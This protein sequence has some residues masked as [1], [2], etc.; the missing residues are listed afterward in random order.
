MEYT[1]EKMECVICMQTTDKMYKVNCGSS[2]DHTMCIGCEGEWRSKMPLQDGMRT[3][4]CPTCRQPELERTVESL[5][6]ELV[7]MNQQDP[8]EVVV[9]RIM[10]Q[11]AS[12]YGA[13]T[14]SMLRPTLVSMARDDH[15]PIAA[16]ARAAV[17]R[18]TVARTTIARTSART[19]ER[20][21]PPIVPCASG[22]DCRSRSVLT[23]RTKTHMK[24]RTC[25]VV[26]CCRNCRTCLTC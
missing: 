15:A 2:V 1:L 11:F 16:V 25:N 24:C 7:R 3:M 9:Q 12:I 4:T 19:S 10:N 26:A 6:R 22:S 20:T 21:R 18:T 13:E 14:A 8:V 23:T 5:Q 17:A